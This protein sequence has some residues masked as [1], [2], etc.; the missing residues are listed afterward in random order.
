METRDG[1]YRYLTRFA[2]PVISDKNVIEYYNV[3]LATLIVRK[4][5]ERK[6]NYVRQRSNDR[7]KYSIFSKSKR[8]NSGEVGRK[9][10]VSAQA[11]FNGTKMVSQSEY[12]C[13]AGENKFHFEFDGLA[14]IKGACK[15]TYKIRK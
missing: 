4:S 15:F 11:V 5:K 3:Y 7:K 14:E 12:Q 1:W 13:L 9:I 10:G 2:L 6:I 8:F